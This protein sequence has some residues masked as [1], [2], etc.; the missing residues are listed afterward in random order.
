MIPDREIRSRIV[1]NPNDEFATNRPNVNPIRPRG[2]V[3]DM[4]MPATD[5][6]V[7]IDA[8]DRNRRRVK[9]LTE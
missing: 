2:I 9:L 8:Y 7:A 3:V 6:S 4:I 1:I 5:N